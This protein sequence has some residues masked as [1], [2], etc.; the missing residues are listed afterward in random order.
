MMRHSRRLRRGNRDYGREF[1]RLYFFKIHFEIT[2]CIATI[3]DSSDVSLQRTI[4]CICEKYLRYLF[5]FIAEEKLA[6]KVRYYSELIV[7]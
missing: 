3:E 6:T 4:M 1:L 2:L 7:L 5:F